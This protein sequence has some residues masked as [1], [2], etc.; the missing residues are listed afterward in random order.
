[1]TKLD[2]LL[3]AVVGAGF[4]LLTS[5]SIVSAQDILNISQPALNTGLPSEQWG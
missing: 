2:G 4:A 3:P 1:M 5:I